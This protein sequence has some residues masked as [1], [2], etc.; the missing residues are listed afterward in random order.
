M[1]GPIGRQQPLVSGSRAINGYVNTVW[2][3]GHW[4]PLYELLLSGT[5]IGVLLMP[6]AADALVA[7]QLQRV[8]PE[9]EMPRLP[10]R[11]LHPKVNRTSEKT[12]QIVAFLKQE[13]QFEVF[14][15]TA[16]SSASGQFGEA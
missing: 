8:L 12:R 13:L 11:L 5:G 7:G 10:I 2:T 6:A 14:P 3:L 9:Y 16:H 1:Q 15:D 4:R